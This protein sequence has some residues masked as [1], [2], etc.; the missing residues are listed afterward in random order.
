[1][2][3]QIEK[4]NA[5]GKPVAGLIVEPIQGEGG[6]NQASAEF[7]R[8]LQQV[9]KEVS[10]LR[11]NWLVWSGMGVLKVV[12]GLQGGGDWF[13]RCGKGIGGWSAR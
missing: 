12:G 1:M 5:A 3:R 7:F 9:C 11:S 10:V 6:D 2:R 8:E 4:Y 13:V